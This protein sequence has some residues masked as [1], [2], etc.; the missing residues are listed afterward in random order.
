RVAQG[1]RPPAG[2]LE[3]ERLPG[4]GHEVGARAWGR[5]RDGWPIARARRGT[6]DGAEDVWM[7]QAHRQRQLSTG[8]D[9]EHRPVPGGQREAPRGPHPRTSSTKNRSWAANRPG[10]KPG[11][12]SWSRTV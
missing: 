7:P 8:R 11:E 2:V 12:Y 6:E 9:T 4:A 5:H 1:S 3:E 10:S